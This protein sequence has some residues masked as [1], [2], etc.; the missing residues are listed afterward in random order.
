LRFCETAL[1]PYLGTH[2][3][4]INDANRLIKEMLS[5]FS[6]DLDLKLTPI[7]IDRK[8]I[9]SVFDLTDK[10]VIDITPVLLEDNLPI[11]VST[12]KYEC[13]VKSTSL[14]RLEFLVKDA[15]LQS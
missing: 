14:Y 12:D 2:E 10:F 13:T 9:L 4:D 3:E 15:K 8:V 7:R 1:W 11:S 5:T 6:I